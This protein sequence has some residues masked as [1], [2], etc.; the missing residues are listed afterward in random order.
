MKVGAWLGETCEM[1]CSDIDRRS[2]EGSSSNR[3]VVSGVGEG[4]VTCETKYGILWGRGETSIALRP[5]EE[6]GTSG[7]HVV[8]S[9]ASIGGVMSRPY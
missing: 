6:D 2:E 8:T 5:G 7:V 9:S 4:S 3:G 1:W